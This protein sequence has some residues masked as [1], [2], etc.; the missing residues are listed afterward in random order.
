MASAT[1]HTATSRRERRWRETHERIIE[2]ATELFGRKEFS[3]ITAL[4]IAEMADVA[5]KTFY[6]HFSTRQHRRLADSADRG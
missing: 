5:E 1:P 4:E 3:G 6:N 2:A